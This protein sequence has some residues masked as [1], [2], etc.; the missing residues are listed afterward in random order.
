MSCNALSNKTHT[1]R[2]ADG[3]GCA[4]LRPRELEVYDTSSVDKVMEMFRGI[5]EP[6]EVYEFET[7]DALERFIED[8]MRDADQEFD[9]VMDALEDAREEQEFDEL[10][11]ALRQDRVEEGVVVEKV[12]LDVLKEY[13]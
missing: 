7:N 10:M 8:F 12:R 4:C 2:Y 1:I 3:E 11:Q 5:A 13:N 6:A 9:D